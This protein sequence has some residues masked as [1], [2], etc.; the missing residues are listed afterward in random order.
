MNTTMLDQIVASKRRELTAARRR[1][2]LEELQAQALKAPPVRD[3]RAALAGSGPIRLIGEVKKA[4]PSVGVIRDDF[5]PVDIARIYQESGAACISVLTD[6]P[7][8]QGHLSHLARVRAAVVLPLL[9]KDF[10]I[11]EYQVVEARLAGADAILLIAEILGTADLISLQKSAWDLGMSVLV[12]LYDEMNL[13]RVLDAGA[14]II[15]INN[16]NLRTFVTDI[17][18]T[19]E[20]RGEIPQGIMVVSESGIQNRHDV[21]RLEAAGVSAILVGESLMRATDIGS[22]V[23]QLLGLVPQA[24][25]GA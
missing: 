19:L 5:D 21:Q 2:P 13:P 14:N 10:I 22:A 23:Q 4:S 6:V 25:P 8:F 12:E 11:E 24:S 17:D 15:G 3:F 18:H 7:Y 20:L 9:R 16:R 1:M